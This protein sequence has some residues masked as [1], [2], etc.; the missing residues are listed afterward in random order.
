MI[1][2]VE[3]A[4]DAAI[5]G[6]VAVASGGILMAA[7]WRQ[8]VGFGVASDG[9]LVCEAPQKQQ[10]K[11]LLAVATAAPS[12]VTAAVLALV[13]GTAVVVSYGAST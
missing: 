11:T 3:A 6:L 10:A 7:V 13:A 2:L 5:I 9:G 12:A 1:I 4:N 8:P